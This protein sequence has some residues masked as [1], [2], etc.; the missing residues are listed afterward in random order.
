MKDLWTINRQLLV[1]RGKCH[2]T[3]LVDGNQMLTNS[4]K[5]NGL[6]LVI[7]V[8]VLYRIEAK[9]AIILCIYLVK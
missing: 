6:A 4:I 1:M 8:V 7:E 5:D 3:R 2:C 9:I